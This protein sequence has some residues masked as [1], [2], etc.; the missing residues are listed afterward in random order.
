[1]VYRKRGVVGKRDLA[2][3]MALRISGTG[4]QGTRT[5]TQRHEVWKKARNRLASSWLRVSPAFFRRAETLR[6]RPALFFVTFAPKP[7]IFSVF[8]VTGHLP[9]VTFRNAPPYGPF[10]GAEMRNG[11]HPVQFV[12]EPVLRL[13]TGRR[14]A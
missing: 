7:Q 3:P 14:G 6:N 4:I 9:S 11:R 2:D 13:A 10:I 1:M 8:R 12:K 5:K